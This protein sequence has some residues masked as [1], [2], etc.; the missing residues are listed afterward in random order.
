MTTDHIIY[1]L[2]AVAVIAMVALGIL[3]TK[4]FGGKI[5]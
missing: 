1:T 5:R 2:V 4:L 3:G